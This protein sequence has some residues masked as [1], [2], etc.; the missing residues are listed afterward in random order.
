MRRL[1]MMVPA[2]C[3]VLA[4]LGCGDDD[5]GTD[6]E[7]ADEQTSGAPTSEAPQEVRTPAKVAECTA[8]ASTTGAHEAEWQGQAKVRTGG[9][10]ADDPGPSAVYTSTHQSNRLA[11]YSPGTEFKGSVTLLAEGVAYSSDPAD[12]ASLDIDEHGEGASVDVS[13]TSTGGDTIDVVAEFT[14]DKEKKQ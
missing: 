12:A 13:L 9:R 1:L 2:V 14:C 11:V 7:K 3:L 5:G 6:E 8:V 4:T 10:L